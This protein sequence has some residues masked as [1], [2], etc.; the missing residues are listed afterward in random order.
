M[1]AWGD[2]PGVAGITAAVALDHDR[3]S[4]QLRDGPGM[5]ID[6][7]KLL[8]QP[9][10]LDSGAGVMTARRTPDGVVIEPSIQN[11][12]LAMIVTLAAFVICGSFLLSASTFELGRYAE[13]SE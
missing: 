10:K 5:V 6:A 3:L 11:S 12:Q 7:P 1:Q 4:I 13:R 9:V 2:V 8:R